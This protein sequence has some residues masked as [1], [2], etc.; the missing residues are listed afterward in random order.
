MPQQT[1]YDP[2]RFLYP[3]DYVPQITYY[4]TLADVLADAPSYPSQSPFINSYNTVG[5]DKTKTINRDSNEKTLT[6]QVGDIIDIVLPSDYSIDFGNTPPPTEVG[7]VLDWDPIVRGAKW[8]EK[9]DELSG[10][11]PSFHSDVIRPS[12][13]KMP[14]AG[15]NN[16]VYTYEAIG[17]GEFEFV[18]EYSSHDYPEVI[19]DT[20][21]LLIKVE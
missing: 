11:L 13:M 21:S 4:E 6:F 18:F 7:E 10:N 9:P 1:Y 16:Q 19:L 5:R 15:D 12:A 2:A 3:P 8:N 14:V 20:F 17:E